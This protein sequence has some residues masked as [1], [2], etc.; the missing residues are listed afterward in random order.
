[1]LPGQW[2]F[3]GKEPLGR[4]NTLGATTLSPDKAKNHWSSFL[5]VGRCLNLGRILSNLVSLSHIH[6]K[7]HTLNIELTFVYS[8]K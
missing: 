1:M 6:Q 7:R 5:E 8:D 2:S 4:S 3:T